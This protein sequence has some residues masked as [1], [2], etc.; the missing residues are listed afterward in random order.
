MLHPFIYNDFYSDSIVLNFFFI[1]AFIILVAHG[2]LIVLGITL[3]FSFKFIF[4]DFIIYPNIEI[5]HSTSE[6]CK[7]NIYYIIEEKYLIIGKRK[8]SEKC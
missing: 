8:D 2:I 6:L 4:K 5:L 7:N 1:Y 3:S